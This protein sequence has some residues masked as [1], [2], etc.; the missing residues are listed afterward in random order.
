MH[1]P[2]AKA[3]LT[4]VRQVKLHF[5]GGKCDS[6]LILA[7]EVDRFVEASK[8]LHFNP[9]RNPHNNVET[10][11]IWQITVAQME[12]R[13]PFWWTVPDLQN[14]GDARGASIIDGGIDRAVWQ[15]KAYL[16]RIRAE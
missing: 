8:R 1:Y 10:A 9:G 15:D 13:G 16:A 12:V 11:K 2:P 6:Y 7:S 3:S 14:N 4:D 5:V